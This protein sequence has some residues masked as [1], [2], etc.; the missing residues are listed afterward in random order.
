MQEVRTITIDIEI[1][2]QLAQI[3]IDQGLRNY[4]EVLNNLLKSQHKVQSIQQTL[5]GETKL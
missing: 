2:K 1:W 5:Q 3:K 4:N